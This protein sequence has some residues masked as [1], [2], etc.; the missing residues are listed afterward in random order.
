[1]SPRQP[2]A[3]DPVVAAL[4]ARCSFPPA[5]GPDGPSLTVAVNV[6]D[7]SAVVAPIFAAA[8]RAVT[9]GL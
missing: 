9:V 6:S 2:S 7:L 3:T 4:L 1:M 5:D 8:C